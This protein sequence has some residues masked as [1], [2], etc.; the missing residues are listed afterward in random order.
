MTDFKPK[1][2]PGFEQA[3]KDTAQPIAKQAPPPEAFR[4]SALRMAMDADLAKDYD[5]QGRMT[6]DVDKL[7]SGAR[8]IEDYL[9]NGDSKSEDVSGKAD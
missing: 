1:M 8:K 4:M 6:T 2:P 9:K 5:E 7:I 3:P